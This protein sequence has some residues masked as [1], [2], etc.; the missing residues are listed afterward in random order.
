MNYASPST[1]SIAVVRNMS[2]PP[3]HFAMVQPA[4]IGDPSL[5]DGLV[6]DLGPTIRRYRDPAEIAARLLR[7]LGLPPAD[8]A[9]EV[10]RRR[11]DHEVEVRGLAGCAA[12]RPAPKDE[13][14]RLRPIS[15]FAL[16]LVLLSK[17]S[18]I[19]WVAR[20]TPVIDRET[21]GRRLLTRDAR[22]GGS[23]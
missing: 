8:D 13:G 2:A 7:H 6:A 1:R 16:A 19:V 5:G 9:L 21:L 14:G 11:I 3:R 17:S 4:R 15:D 20:K 22:F 18:D 10:L 23:P 12:V